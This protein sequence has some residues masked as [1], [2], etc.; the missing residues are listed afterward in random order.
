MRPRFALPLVALLTISACGGGGGGT[1]TTTPTPLPPAPTWQ[2][3]VDLVSSGY[4]QGALLTGDG[5]GGVMATWTHTGVD[6]GGTPY[7]ELMAARLGPDGTWEAPK[8]LEVSTGTN[9]LQPPVAA[10]DDQG[11]GY[12]A[13]FSAIPRSTLTALRTVPVDLKATA[14]FGTRATAQALDL[15]GLSDLHLAVGSDG[16]ALAAWFYLRTN[17]L[18]TDYP[19]IQSSRFGVGTGWSQPAHHWL[20]QFSHQGLNG[21]QG[22]GRGTYLL[23]IATGDDAWS[24]NQL[25]DFPVGQEAST[26]V[27]GW[28]PASQ[29]ALPANY[30]AAL[31]LDGQGRVDVWMVYPDASVGDPNLQA[32]PRTRSVTGTWTVGDKVDL[33]LRTHTL[34][35]FREVNG[36]GWLAGLG[37]Q[38]L[39]VA[40]L[41]GMAPGTPTSLLPA[42]TQIEVMVGT[43]DATGRPTLVWIQRGTG[44]VYEGIGWSR[45]DGARWTVPLII[46]GTTG[47]AILSLSAVAG[48]G[49]LAVGWVEV[50]NR[51]LL[52]RTALWK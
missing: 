45:W 17:A 11:K 30:Q 7:W 10:L 36:A 31:A 22:D 48:P 38:G 52:L 33:P 20:N 43:R 28:M 18:V 14:P 34:A 35:A 46:P 6:G 13:W 32:W 4:D 8:S 39:W 41:N 51:T 50:G 29:V 19:T 44:G 40:P 21:L 25:L 1:A 42:T 24:E 15:R 27:P 9:D 47:K 37:S 49:G 3:P 23:S 12:V 2:V 5:K 26:T 16:S